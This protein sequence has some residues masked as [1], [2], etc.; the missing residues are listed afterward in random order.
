MLF[1]DYY[2]DFSYAPK[3]DNFRNTSQ[4]CSNDIYL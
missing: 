3:V 1:S 2:F 4:N